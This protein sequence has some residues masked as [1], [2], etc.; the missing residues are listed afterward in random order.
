MMSGERLLSAVERI[1]RLHE[2]KKHIESDIRDIY[3]EV[4]AEGFDKKV[5]REV[6]KRRSKDPSE[7]TEFESMIELY[8]QSIAEA[9]RGTRATHAR[10]A[11]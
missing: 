10:E 8:E 2:E 5:L 11:A 9:S 1:E 7:R 6:V 3:A 4:A